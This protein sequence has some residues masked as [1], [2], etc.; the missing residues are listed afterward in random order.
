MTVHPLP[1]SLI[2]A[3]LALFN[4]S[5]CSA[6][7][8]TKHCFPSEQTLSRSRY[9]CLASKK[10]LA[11]PANGYDAAGHAHQLH[12][13][14]NDRVDLPAEVWI[15]EATCPSSASVNASYNKITHR[16]ETTDQ[17]YQEGRNYARL[18]CHDASWTGHYTASQ[19]S[20]LSQHAHTSS[21]SHRYPSEGVIV[22][23]TTEGATWS[24]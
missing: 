18:P 6:L 5:H 9:L 14:S 15:K 13:L 19:Q 20:T 23:S 4:S 22:A 17:T 10:A 11:A 7:P 21:E 3:T 12:R 2:A 16:G 1:L 24:A 8:K